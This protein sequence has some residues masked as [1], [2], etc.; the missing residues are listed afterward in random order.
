MSNITFKGIIRYFSLAI[1]MFSNSAVLNAGGLVP[2]NLAAFL[3]ATFTANSAEIT[4]PWWTLAANSNYLYYAETEDECVWNLVEVLPITTSNFSG[5]YSGV[6]A[7][8]VL[9]REW[10][11][12]ECTYND[13]ASVIDNVDPEEITY[14]WYAQDED[15]NIWYMGEATWD[16]ESSEGSF[17]AG[18]DGAEAGI[19]ILGQPLKGTFY[20]Q[21]HYE[22]EAEDWG[23]VLNFKPDDDLLCMKTKEWSP[24]EHGDIEHKFYCSD[25]TYGELTMIQELKGKTVFFDLI[26]KNINPPASPSWPLPSPYPDC[27]E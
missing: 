24:L 18:C 20:Q 22:D 17:I 9:D 11:D 27:T 8:I 5:D 2:T 3:E 4:S 15:K 1:L 19:V 25:G 7:R 26:D 23:K 13:F 16:G 14:D 12:E 21:E 6:N 10:V